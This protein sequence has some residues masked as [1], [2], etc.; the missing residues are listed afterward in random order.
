MATS[1]S[2]IS[3]GEEN[4]NTAVF[5]K[6]TDGS[7]TEAM[8]S[9]CNTVHEDS[10]DDA[11]CSWKTAVN[12]RSA[13]SKKRPRVR[14]NS[15]GML[16]AKNNKIPKFSRSTPTHSSM[17]IVIVGLENK[18][19]CRANPVKV[20]K[21]IHD[22]VGKIKGMVKEKNMLTVRCENERQVLKLLQITE[23]AG[24]NVKATQYSGSQV[25]TKGVIHK[26]DTQISNEEIEE[27]LKEQNVVNAKRFLKKIRGEI[28]ATPSVLI[29]FKG[30]NLPETLNFLYEVRQVDN[31]FPP[32][33]RCYKCQLFGHIKANCKGKLR[34]VRCGGEHEFEECASKDN[35]KCLR[36][37]ENHSAAFQGCKHYIEAKQIQ[38]IKL[39][40]NLTYAQATKAR[41]THITSAGNEVA[42]NKTAT[43]NDKISKHATKRNIESIANSQ[44]TAELNPQSQIQPTAPLRK[45]REEREK[46]GDKQDAVLNIRKS[47]SETE[48]QSSVN[49]TTFDLI[50]FILFVIRKLPQSSNDEHFFETVIQASKD[51][52]KADITMEMVKSRLK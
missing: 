24:I 38:K 37:G 13:K 49:V 17:K 29:T 31:Y 18:N 21:E 20:V 23:L 40:G 36:C 32:V 10:D 4:Y 42:A 39:E 41:R 33:P 27:V 25:T 50:M 30:K 2:S 45:R 19:V 35:P 43:S 34:C 11:N 3:S 7:G 14:S 6:Y 1:F 26:I 16:N 5:E 9:D 48:N 15:D 52:L 51:F 28:V 44:Q 46:D 12:K 47:K 8:S 22:L